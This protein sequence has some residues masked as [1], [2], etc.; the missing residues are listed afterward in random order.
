MTE[1]ELSAIEQRWK[2]SAQSRQDVP[3]LI[4]ALRAAWTPKKRPRGELGFLEEQCPSCNAHLYLSIKEEEA[5]IAPICLNA[6]H[7]GRESARRFRKLFS[8]RETR[9]YFRNET[10]E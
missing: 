1:Q 4:A 3:A 9:G 7:L 10:V 2:E 6:C 5:G 8:E